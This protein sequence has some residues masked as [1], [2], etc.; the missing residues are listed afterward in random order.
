MTVD[1]DLDQRVRTQRPRSGWTATSE[2]MRTWEVIQDSHGHVGPAVRARL[3]AVAAA[4]AVA[5]VG[6]TFA[7]RALGPA[8]DVATPRPTNGGVVTIGQGTTY[9]AEDLQAVMA[10][11]DT[12][13]VGTVLTVTDRDEDAAWTTHAVAVKETIAGQPPTEIKVRQHGYVDRQGTVHIIENQALIEVDRT[14]VFATNH[15]PSL[16]VYTV[17]PGPWAARPTEPEGQPVLVKRY[18]DAR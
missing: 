2:G 10:N 16:D 3:F 18:R 6:V 7:I 17:A 15:E 5:V 1:N 12:V 13:F 14:Y 11:T 4:L 8:Y 9:D